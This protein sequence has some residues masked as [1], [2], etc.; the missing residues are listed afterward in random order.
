[1]RKPSPKP[2]RRQQTSPELI[3]ECLDFLERKFYLGHPIPFS[4]DRPRLLAWVVLWPARWFNKR[5][6]TISP[7]RYR[8]IFM[9]VFLEAIAH[10][11]QS[12]ITYPPAYLAHVIQSHFDHHGEEYYEAAKS[13]RDNTVLKGI[14]A[15]QLQPSAAQPDPIREMAQAARLLATKKKAPLTTKPN[16]LTLI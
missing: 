15:G 3:G 13:I 7:E 5:G 1:M 4:K 12:K 11:F 9:H 10:G 6:V 16:Q 8:E 2:V 14:L